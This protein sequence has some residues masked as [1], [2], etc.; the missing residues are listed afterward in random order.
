M[1]EPLFAVTV[2]T[3]TTLGLRVLGS[4]PPL[5]HFE[6]WIC[7]SCGYTELYAHGIPVN[8]ASIVEKH[9]DQLRIVDAE[10]QGQGPYR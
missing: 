1:T 2:V 6:T 5:G 8:I 3:V 10:P 9:P 7:L 4:M